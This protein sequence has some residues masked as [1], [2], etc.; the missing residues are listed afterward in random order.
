MVRHLE[1][2]LLEATDDD[3]VLLPANGTTTTTTATSD[4][5]FND[6]QV[7]RNSI[8]LYGGLLV[9][10]LIYFGW[11]RRQFPKLYNLRS[12]VTKIHTE[13]ADDQFGFLSW[14]WRV[15]M[16]TDDEIMQECGLDAACFIRL[17]QMGFHL[18]M[19]GC[20]N[21]LWLIPVYV[22]AATDASSDAV[23]KTTIANVAPGS[24]RFYAT[25]LGAYIFFGYAMYYILVRMRPITINLP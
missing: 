22:T 1:D 9:L 6:S 11:A 10:I 19:V 5:T 17:I 20:F 25:V 16:I 13:L 3:F 18:S 2:L 14:L 8:F 12:W 21:A 23:V 24:E 15:Y 7:L 4:S